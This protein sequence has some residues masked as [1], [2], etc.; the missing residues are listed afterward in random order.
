[1]LHVGTP[2]VTIE[3]GVPAENDS[4]QITEVGH[5]SGVPTMSQVCLQKTTQVLHDE[6]PNIPIQMLFHLAQ[7]C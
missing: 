3:P 4:S 2:T 6:T 7:L 1:M 5:G